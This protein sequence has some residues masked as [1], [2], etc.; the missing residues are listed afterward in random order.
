MTGI[1]GRRGGRFEGRRFSFVRLA[2]TVAGLALLGAAGAAAVLLPGWLEQ[3]AGAA[4]EQRWFAGYYDV[5][6]ETGEA[7]ARSNLNEMPGGAVLAFVVA[8]DDTSCTPSWGIG[9][10]LDDADEQFD[11]DRRIARMQA[12]GLQ[13]I[14]S[15]GGLANTELATACTDED[16]LV[17]AY[18]QVI[19]RYD[20]D[21]IDL[22]IE[23]GDLTDVAAAQRRATAIAQVQQARAADGRPLAVWV[24][25]PVA[26]DGLTADG[27]A[28]V[29]HLLDGGVDLAGVNV[30]TMDYG[31]D[32]GGRS[33]GEVAIAALESTADQV[34]SLWHARGLALPDDGVW[35]MLGAT[36]M[37]GRNDVAGEIFTLDDASALNRFANERG[38]MRLSLWSVNRDRTCG[39]NYPNPT[40]VSTACSGV[41][42]AGMSFADLLAD[43]FDLALPPATPTAAPA[44]DDPATSPYPVWSSTQFYSAGVKVVWR[45]GVFISKW[46]AQGG[47]VPDDPAI[48]VESS[49]WSYLGPVLA[50]DTP[51]S[52]PTLPA[53]TY[54]EWD[55]ETLY[56]QGERVLFDG[57]G[58]EARWW[59]K[60]QSPDRSL[61][62]HDYSPW[63]PLTDP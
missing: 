45:G 11:I 18:T 10:P 55:P 44:V 37:I 39:T 50:S 7:L 38:L 59:S 32:L 52:V 5:T 56:Q 9:H 16:A 22:D 62:D 6:L 25:L 20:V 29:E 36:P 26:P 33:M 61:L 27:I 3:P 19:E 43:G 24:T 23:A 49:A 53:G 46:W 60:G 15:F 21:T 34:T 30:M 48:P 2:G 28:A 42:Q 1:T 47:T 41:D 14:I 63:K 17:S 40:V 8:S 4:A 12:L 57:V 54:P 35:A 58:Y 13:A 51:Y 31:V